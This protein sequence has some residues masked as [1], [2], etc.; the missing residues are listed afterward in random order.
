MA[1]AAGAA[2][3]QLLRVRWLAHVY[4]V[5]LAPST[6]VGGLKRK[7]EALTAVQPSRQKLLGVRGAPGE[8]AL[9]SSLALP[10]G[11]LTLLGS[12]D[13]EHEQLAADALLAPDA[14]DD[15]EVDAAEPLALAQR[16]ETLAKV[17]RRVA[18]AKQV[19]LHPPRPGS[20]LLVLDI[21]YTLF[22]HRTTAASPQE[23]ARPYL[24]PFLAAAHAANYDIVIWS[25]TS[26]K[27]IRLKMT[28]LGVLSHDAY[29]VCS[30]YD[31]LSM[32][33]LSTE[34]H[35]VFDCKPLAV[36]WAHQPQWGPHN[37]VMFDD[38]SRNFVLN[39]QSGLKIRPFRNAH[40]ARATDTELRDLARYLTLSACEGMSGGGGGESTLVPSTTGDATLTLIC[41]AV[42]DVPDFR[43]LD[44]RRWERYR[45][46][47]GVDHKGEAGGGEEG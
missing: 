15:F 12:V 18:A 17:Q 26:V 36:V 7:L 39:P 38:L 2:A 35:G 32:V 40:A 37:T 20:K 22:D 43:T 33:T 19:A 34:E 30:L 14:A 11:G 41:R 10:R 8:D 46:E 1:D 5:E 16:P 9:L 47:E 29:R 6:T 44:H 31:H 24:H 3:P 27:W 4:D 42:A 45:G 23:L 25:A 28:E 21:D 13:A